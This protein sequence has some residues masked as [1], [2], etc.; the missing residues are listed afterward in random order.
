MNQDQDTEGLEFEVRLRA[1]KLAEDKVGSRVRSQRV[2]VRQ[3]AL[4]EVAALAE[5]AEIRELA[6]EQVL[7]RKIGRSRKKKA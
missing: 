5:S 6:R 4:L 3:K 7:A 2:S 1:L